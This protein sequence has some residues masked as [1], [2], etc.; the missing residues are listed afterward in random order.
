MAYT[1]MACIAMAYSLHLAVPCG[2]LIELCSIWLWPIYLW[3][4]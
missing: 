1:I 4:I 3:F 2:E